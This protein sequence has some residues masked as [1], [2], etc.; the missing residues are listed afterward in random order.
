VNIL[1]V[2]PE[3]NANYNA[4]LLGLIELL[5]EAGHRVTY[6]APRMR[7]L[8]QDFTQPF[9]SAV[10]V[11]RAPIDG[12]FIFAPA[13]SFRLLGAGRDLHAWRGY[14]LVLG[15][16]RGIIEAARIARHHAIPHALLSYEIFFGDEMPAGFK[17]PEVEACRDLAFAICQD[18]V[19]TAHLCRENAIRADIVVQIPVA[20]RGFLGDMPKT[21]VLHASL[22][23]AAHRKVALHMG[24][25]ASWT[26]A[27]FLLESTRAWPDAW[28]LVVHERYGATEAT[29]ELIRTHAD[30]GRVHLSEARFADARRMS[31]FIRSAD[32][33]VALYRPGYEDGWTGGNIEHIGLSSGKIATYLQ[34]GVPVATH[35]LGEISTLIRRHG[36][37][38][39]FPLDR[40]FIPAIPASPG[41]ACRELF[42]THLDL[43]R[44]GASF[45]Q[46]VAS[47]Q[48]A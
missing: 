39:V 14:D 2:H 45:L 7:A 46:A 25:F 33:G 38:Q 13:G 23:L 41:K 3:G 12:R 19:R 17:E 35:E 27:P 26:G 8:N 40:P 44:F 28:V 30:P 43:D 42:E 37:G 34:H 9:I 24:S 6:A 32:L 15:I 29:R 5:G 1:L 20:G 10:L 22:G 11:K 31:D 48:G 36:A 4:N 16:D 21:G 18:G 47:H